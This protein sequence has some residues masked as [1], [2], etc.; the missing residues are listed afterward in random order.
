M[1]KETKISEQRGLTS[2]PDDPQMR[3]EGKGSVNETSRNT[4]QRIWAYIVGIGILFALGTALSLLHGINQ[5]REERRRLAISQANTI[6][7]TIFATRRWAME[8][9]SASVLAA[10][11]PR[12]D[13]SI[14]RS[15]RSTQATDG[16]K[17]DKLVKINHFSMMQFIEKILGTEG[18]HVH[19]VSRKA[20]HP[21]NLPDSD[22]ERVSL[23]KLVKG[24]EKEYALAGT[25]GNR[26]FRYMEPLKV[27]AGC[28]RCHGQQ[29]YNIGDVHSAISIAFPYTPFEQSAQRSE[30]REIIAHLLS[31]G[32]ALGILFYLGS[33]I[34]GLT[35]SLQETQRRVRTL[36]GIL[37]MCMNCKKI[38]K[39][40][41]AATDPAAWVPVAEYIRDCSEAEV[42]HGICPEC[43]QKLYGPGG[44]LT[45]S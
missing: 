34:V 29:G 9:G 37:P 31:L 6:S 19:N 21:R 17:D 33:R 4:T 45:E 20:L 26:V 11:T 7:R 25:A 44:S 15:G 24:S 10:Q 36:E 3:T 32:V 23:D 16:D 38:R 12:S 41:A 40:G 30:R 18:F 22:W 5:I 28:I 2:Q 39:E 8:N 42:S 43:M 27:D 14:E 35:Q 1:V 13:P